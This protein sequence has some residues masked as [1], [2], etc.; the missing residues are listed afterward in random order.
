MLNPGASFT[1]KASQSLLSASPAGDWYCFVTY[2]TSDGT[3]HDDPH[4]T[5]FTVKATG[6]VGPTVS[7]VTTSSLADHK[8]HVHGHH[9][10]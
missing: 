10:P 5:T 2:E 4:D 6:G 1:I 9:Q 3:W 7:V 8:R